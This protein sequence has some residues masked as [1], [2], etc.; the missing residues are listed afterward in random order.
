MQI[1]VFLDNKRILPISKCV[2]QFEEPNV[3][4]LDVVAF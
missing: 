4:E 3:G 2:K 1:Y